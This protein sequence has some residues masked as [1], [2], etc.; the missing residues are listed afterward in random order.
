MVKMIMRKAKYL[1]YDFNKGIKKRMYGGILE[2][3]VYKKINGECT[4]GI[5]INSEPF[6]PIV[7]TIFGHYDRANTNQVICT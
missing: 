1:I 2:L 6:H 4:L 3:E 7:Y 5:M